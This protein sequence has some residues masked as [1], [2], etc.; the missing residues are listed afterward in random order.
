MFNEILNYKEQWVNWPISRD[1][2]RKGRKYSR[3]N[4]RKYIPLIYTGE[5]GK[6]NFIS[7]FF[8]RFPCTI[9]I[10]KSIPKIQNAMITKLDKKFFLKKIKDGHKSH[11]RIHLPIYVS[12]DKRCGIWCNKQTNYLKLGKMIIFDASK[13]HT[14][15]NLSDK[16]RIVLSIDI[17]N[18]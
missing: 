3:K 14:I 9:S 16:E 17:L 12:N 1:I 6:L 10:L 15:F 11:L 5:D 18:N 2:D 8:R 4:S 7:N 13:E